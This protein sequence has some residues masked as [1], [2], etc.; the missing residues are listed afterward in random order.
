M[1]MYMFMFMY[2]YIIV[3]S[4]IKT[5]TSARNSITLELIPSE[6]SEVVHFLGL[7]TVVTKRE[8]HQ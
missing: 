2:G 5:K 4:F 1:Y 6:E 8:S 3:E 7:T